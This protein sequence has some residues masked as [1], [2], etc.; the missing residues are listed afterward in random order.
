VD[1]GLVPSV[2]KVSLAGRVVV[3]P[4]S[5]GADLNLEALLPFWLLD[6]ERGGATMTRLLA[7]DREGQLTPVSLHPGVFSFFALPQALPDGW[8]VGSV[9][10]GGRDVLRNG[11]LVGGEPS[12]IEI[13]LRDDAAQIQ[14][15]A[16]DAGRTLLGDARI[17]LI[18]PESERSA[19]ARFPT[20]RAAPDGS[21][22]LS[23]VPP[24]EYRLIALDTVGRSDRIEYWESPD[25]LRQYELR[26]ELIT[27]DPGARLTINPEA[28]RLV[29]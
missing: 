6:S 9:R 8:Y 10:S 1:I 13:V 14:G 24:G 18:P 11:L 21:Y 25:F 7:T 16:R 27:V 5:N 15:V 23:G 22:L 3:A 29:E 20:T 19:L 4:E 26:G 28:I 2:P 17:V 12:P